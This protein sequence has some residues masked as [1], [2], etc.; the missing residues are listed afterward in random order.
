[1]EIRS[2]VGELLPT[3]LQTSW[4]THGETQRR[5]LTHSYYEHKLQV[6]HLR[7]LQKKAQLR[8]LVSLKS[9]FRGREREREREKKK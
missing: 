3:D 6:E 1:M 5:I 7:E 4:Q 2:R 8:A 9:P